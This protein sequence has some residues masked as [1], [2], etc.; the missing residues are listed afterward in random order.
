MLGLTWAFRRPPTPTM[1]AT[2]WEELFAV[3][4]A[5]Q[6]FEIESTD[7]TEMPILAESDY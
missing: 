1:P 7:R 4:E 3:L 5:G 6:K 2:W